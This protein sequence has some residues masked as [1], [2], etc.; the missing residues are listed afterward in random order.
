MWNMSVLD[1]EK[2][3]SQVIIKVTH[4]HSAD[5]ATIAKRK[6]ALLALGSY[7]AAYGVPMDVGLSDIK[8][9][10]SE[11]MRGASAAAAARD[12]KQSNTSSTSTNASSSSFFENENVN[13]AAS[14]TTTNT[15]EASAKNTSSS[16]NID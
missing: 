9:K 15:Y 6:E 13:S 7:Y 10:L 2:T 11:Q 8:G 5:A 14:K 12:T 1:I 16:K 3:L 4:D